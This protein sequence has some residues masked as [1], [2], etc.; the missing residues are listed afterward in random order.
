MQN[1]TNLDLIN[2]YKK[3]FNFFYNEKNNIQ[4]SKHWMRYNI[5]L[6]FKIFKISEK[7]VY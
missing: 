1:T 3:S 5:I 2:I 7:M 6:I 4:Q